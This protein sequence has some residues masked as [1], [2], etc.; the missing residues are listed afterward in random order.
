MLSADGCSEP[1]VAGRIVLSQVLCFFFILGPGRT[2]LVPRV[3][4]LGN[5]VWKDYFFR[6]IMDY[7]HNLKLW[8][9]ILEAAL[10]FSQE[11]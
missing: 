4:R 8:I 5:M 2:L 7:F 9:C 6:R 1:S 3:Q 10:T 11:Q